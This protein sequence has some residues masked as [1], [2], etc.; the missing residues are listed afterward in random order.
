MVC[1]LDYAAGTWLVKLFEAWRDLWLGFPD[2]AELLHRA[3]RALAR[4][5]APSAMPLVPMARIGK[6]EA[7]A[8]EKARLWLKGGLPA[9]HE[10]RA[11]IA[12]IYEG[13]QPAL[14]S[15]RW[16]RWLEI[17]RALLDASETGDVLFAASVLRTMIEEIGRLRALA[18]THEELANGA[19]SRHEQKSA[20]ARRFLAAAWTSILSTKDVEDG[21][22]D[23]VNGP[24]KRMQL[25]R[26]LKQAYGTLNA[27][28][29]PNY[30]SHM[31]ALYPEE[32]ET[33][34][35]IL[36]AIV[37]L[38]DEFYAIS[39][40]LPFP[41]PP[42]APSAALAFSHVTLLET[43][44]E[45]IEG[46]FPEPLAEWLRKQFEKGS[47]HLRPGRILPDSIL[48]EC[49]QDESTSDA[50]STLPQ[51]GGGAEG[52][53]RF[54]I[55]SGA[56]ANDVLQFAAARRAEAE[57]STSFPD[58]PP[59]IDEGDA[60]LDFNRRALQLTMIA[61]TTK[62]S[63]QQT[64]L[65]RQIVAGAPMGIWLSMR[66]LIEQWA[67]GIWLSS[68]IDAALDAAALSATSLQVPESAEPMAH[69]LASYLSALANRRVDLPRPWA[70]K[71]GDDQPFGTLDLGRVIASAF[72]AD[73]FWQQQYSLAC[74]AMHGVTNRA[75][76][77][78]SDRIGSVRGAQTQ[79]A[80]VL[81]RCLAEAFDV[82]IAG[83]HGY[84]RVNHA[85]AAAVGPNGPGARWNLGMGDSLAA[86]HDY[87][88]TGTSSD[89][90]V[91][92]AHIDFHAGANSI[93]QSLCDEDY[94]ALFERRQV[95]WS[96]GRGEGN[97]LYERCDCGRNSW[98]FL[99]NSRDS[100]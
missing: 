71:G 91:I 23:V 67:L 7:R 19:V 44:E 69:S 50:L 26:K 22:R 94:H 29:H 70:M 61:S 77:L 11:V 27:F 89:P 20:L 65:I 10:R 66:P 16:T 97:Q 40:A 30:G 2:A 4:R 15:F 52:L 48:D 33:A 99:V 8:A 13:V 51:R 80:W 32:R 3:E 95:M 64:Q 63:S 24:G 42:A 47:A 78:A 41:P 59:S 87:T 83:I 31:A 46:L 62:V 81:V 93:V 88:G 34:L 6:V 90:F 75:F 12:S 56:S 92:A 74:D 28:V 14:E 73:Q 85:L 39:E 17:E 96:I 38:Y 79:G 25:N 37:A 100:A 54:R 84:W 60:W 45:K 49:M 9:P 18:L 57:L 76:D 36:E 68:D 5:G 35:A 21:E 55:W 72:G 58:G 53:Q 82:A 1:L 86:G 43:F 98:W